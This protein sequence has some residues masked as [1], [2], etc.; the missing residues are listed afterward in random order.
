METSA[1]FNKYIETI[2][3]LLDFVNYKDDRDRV[4]S[5]LLNA[6]YLNF[7]AIASE[8][9]NI[10]PLF[11]TSDFEDTSFEE[12]EKKVEEVK[13]ILEKQDFDFVANFNK[14][15]KQTLS[16]FVFELESKLAPEKVT[17]LRKLAEEGI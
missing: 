7:V 17:E 10:K 3:K 6:S 1:L 5:D 2:G 13:I 8:N 4:K 16:D 14:A 12:F 15:M 9:P 11:S